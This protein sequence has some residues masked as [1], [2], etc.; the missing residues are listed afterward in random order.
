MHCKAYAEAREAKAMGGGGGAK[1]GARAGGK[2]AKEGGGGAGGGK[3]KG[4]QTAKRG[5]IAEYLEGG[6]LLRKLGRSEVPSM[7]KQLPPT[8]ALTLDFLTH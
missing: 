2:A 4:G 7:A 3:G 8:M 5:G 6:E 1:K